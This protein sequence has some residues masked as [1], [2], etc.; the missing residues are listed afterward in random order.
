MVTVSGHVNDTL[1]VLTAEHLSRLEFSFLHGPQ[2]RENSLAPQNHLCLGRLTVTAVA[3]LD[4]QTF[5]QGEQRLEPWSPVISGSGKTK[6]S[7]RFGYWL[8][9]IGHKSPLLP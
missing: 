8:L 9:H 1:T 7:C 4:S 5:P 2:G 6:R 3:M